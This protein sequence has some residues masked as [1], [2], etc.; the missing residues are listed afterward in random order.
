MLSYKDYYLL[1]RN[2]NMCIFQLASKEL[3]TYYTNL[4]IDAYCLT[5]QYSITFLNLKFICGLSNKNLVPR[6]FLILSLEV[7]CLGS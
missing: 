6:L 2:L 5:K 7:M 1:S 4:T 3:N